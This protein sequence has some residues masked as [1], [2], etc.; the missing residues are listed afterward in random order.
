MKSA[1]STIPFIM[2]R[3]E[4]AAALLARYH[5]GGKSRKDTKIELTTKFSMGD[6]DAEMVLQEIDRVKARGA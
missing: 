3:N 5:A 1:S 6:V 2:L 4:R